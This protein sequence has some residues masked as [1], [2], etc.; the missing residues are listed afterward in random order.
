MQSSEGKHFQT[1]ED[2]YYMKNFLEDYIMYVLVFVLVF[3]IILAFVVYLNNNN[4]SVHIND[5][6]FTWAIVQ[7][8]NG[9]LIEGHVTSWRDFKDSDMIQI[10]IDD[11]LTIMTH[12]S[13]VL[14]CSEQP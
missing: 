6:L 11:K 5:A 8:G 2:S 7:L 13:N 4:Q 10:I 14:L 9:E 1:R 12:S 3:V